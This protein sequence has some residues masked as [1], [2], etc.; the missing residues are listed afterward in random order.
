MIDLKFKVYDPKSKIM[1]EW[2]TVKNGNWDFSDF[3]N[4][5]VFLQFT[6]CKD[7]NNTDIYNGDILDFPDNDRGVCWVV[8]NDSRRFDIPIGFVFS[9]FTLAS[10]KPQYLHPSVDELVIIGN[11]YENPEILK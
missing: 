8:G 3:Q 11:I 2:E 6:G 5:Q 9:L 4:G 1:H 10:T 7:K